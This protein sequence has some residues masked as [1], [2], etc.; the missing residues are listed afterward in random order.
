MNSS[1]MEV[2]PNREEMPEGLKAF[3]S[4]EMDEEEMVIADMSM[5][6]K[7]N[8]FLP[9]KLRGEERLPSGAFDDRGLGGA[10]SNSDIVASELSPEET[11]WA[12]LGSLKA[13]F[14]IG[15]AYIVGL[16]LVVLTMFLLFKYFA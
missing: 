9:R 6:R 11:K 10:P 16:G 14:M 13:A 8:V 12:I 2:K 7:P 3:D 1:D 5:V 15:G 4:E